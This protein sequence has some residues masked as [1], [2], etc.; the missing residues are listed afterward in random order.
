MIVFSILT[1]QFVAYLLEFC[2]CSCHLYCIE[3]FVHCRATFVG[4]NIYGM[5]CDSLIII[6]CFLS[7]QVKLMTTIYVCSGNGTGINI[8]ITDKL[9]GHDIRKYKFYCL[10][11]FHISAFHMQMQTILD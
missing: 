10:Q 9:F 3:L 7:L 2:Y 6:L 4:C 5:E 11:L 1:F 8:P